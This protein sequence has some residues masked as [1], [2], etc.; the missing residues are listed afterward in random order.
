VSLVFNGINNL[1]SGFFSIVGTNTLQVYGNV[2]AITPSDA[3]SI[4]YNM[5]T[6]QTQEAGGNLKFNP[7][8][9][10]A[11]PTGDVNQ[12]GTIDAFDLASVENDLD[13]ATPGCA[14]GYPTDLNC[15]GDFVDAFD[16]SVAENNQGLISTPPVPNYGTSKNPVTVKPGILK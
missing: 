13:C 8:G 15:D 9:V 5:T 2:T 7:N 6:A 1:K 14:S 16:L 3:S 11:I 12:D 4:T 10:W